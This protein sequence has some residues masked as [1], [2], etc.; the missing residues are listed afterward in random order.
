VKKKGCHLGGK[1]RHLAAQT[2]SKKKA[3]I[4]IARKLLVL[5]HKLLGQSSP[6]EEPKS[7]ELTDEKRKKAVQRHLR[8]LAKLGVQVDL[9][10]KNSKTQH[11]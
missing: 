7:K 3:L 10:L 11:A 1:Y 8:E 5:V 6:Y 9:L 2:G 4:A